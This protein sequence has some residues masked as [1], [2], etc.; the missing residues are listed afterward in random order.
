MNSG[1]VA[2]R[3]ASANRVVMGITCGRAGLIRF[4]FSSCS[5]RGAGWMLRPM[6]APESV[7]LF[8]VARYR[9]AS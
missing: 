4:L 3:R 5:P 9:G 8:A 7:G 6:L 1:P 2:V